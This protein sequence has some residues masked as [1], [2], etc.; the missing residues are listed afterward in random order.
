VNENNE[1][2]EYSKTSMTNYNRFKIFNRGSP[3]LG[4]GL[5]IDA[6]TTLPL[7]FDYKI[8]F[9][10]VDIALPRALEVST[11]IPI[12]IVIDCT[13]SYFNIVDRAVG[14]VFPQYNR[15]IS[16]TTEYEILTVLRDI[17]VAK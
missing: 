8:K 2:F 16:S 11:L 4:D 3:T 13:F 9:Y 5:Y 1:T 14:A 10:L 15:I 12:K 6:T 17:P 7:E